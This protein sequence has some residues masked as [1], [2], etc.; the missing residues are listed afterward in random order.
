MRFSSITPLLTLSLTAFAGTARAQDAPSPVVETEAPAATSDPIDASSTKEGKGK[1]PKRAPGTLEWKARVFARAAQETTTVSNNGTPSTAERRRLTVP[2]ARFGLRYQFVDWLMLEAEGDLT[3][4]SVIRD[5]FIQAKSKRLRA[6][7]GHFKMPVSAI[8]LESPWTLPT[9]GRGVI[10]DRLEEHMLAIGRRP[11]FLVSAQ[12]G[13][14]LDPELSLSAFQGAYLTGDAFDP[15]VE[16]LDSGN[17]SQSLVARLA[18]TPAGQDVAVYAARVATL[19][20]MNRP[21]HFFIGGFDATLDAPFGLTGARAWLEGMGGQTFYVEELVNRDTTFLTARAIIAWRWGGAAEGAHYIEPFAFAGL[22]DPDLDRARD[23]IR[24][25]S[26][27]LNLGLWQ[28]ARLTLQFE[29]A[30]GQDLLPG[31]LFLGNLNL[32][33]H[34]AGLVQ[35]GAAF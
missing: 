24:E 5:A 21:R 1:K 22:L 9:A 14:A 2:S 19:G 3:S 4:R 30:S 31:Q 32:K 7:A 33:S 18:V 11:G 8:T 17:D 6:R 27:G 34:R 26:I 12:A 23:L 16:T 28:S 13:G 25:L 15:D 29:T 10:Q 35:V 20:L